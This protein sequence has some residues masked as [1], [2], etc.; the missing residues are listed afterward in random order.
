MMYYKHNRNSV[1]YEMIYCSSNLE[2]LHVSS[3]VMHL[4]TIETYGLSTQNQALQS[5]ISKVAYDK[6]NIYG[7]SEFHN[8]YNYITPYKAS[9]KE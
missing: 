9:S 2:K 6:I 8:V 1:S 4:S 5:M 7:T 3:Y